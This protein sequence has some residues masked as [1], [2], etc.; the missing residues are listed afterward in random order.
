MPGI[1]IILYA[2]R[3][4]GVLVYIQTILVGVGVMAVVLYFIK[5]A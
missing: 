2:L 4:L 5:R 1:S 3:E